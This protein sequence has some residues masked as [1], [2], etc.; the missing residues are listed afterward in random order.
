[1]LNHYYMDVGLHWVA[2]VLYIGATVANSAGVIFQKPRAE[3]AG[4]ALVMTGL[5]AHSVAL[6]YRWITSG[7]GPYMVRYEVLSS[8]AWLALVLF[9]LFKARYPKIRSAS[10]VIFPAIF[11][12]IGC[13]LFLDPAAQ[14]LPPSLQSIWLIFHVTFYKIA[15][16]TLLIA[17]AFAILYLL[18]MKAA[19]HRYAMLPSLH[20]IDTYAYRF[21]GF[22]FIFWAIAMLAGSIWAYQSWGRFW[23]WDAI[24]SWSLITWA[25]FGVYLHLRR[26]F[27]WHGEKAAWMFIVCFAVSIMTLFFTPL[28]ATSIHAEYFR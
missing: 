12:L 20:D 28:L 9:L 4:N 23:G 10:L 25:L 19:S 18:K 1:M 5:V 21:T 17:L 22:G 14:K 27:G 2:V 15:L 24:E 11:L 8:D 13:G 6:A 7:H 16:G 3:K 26:F